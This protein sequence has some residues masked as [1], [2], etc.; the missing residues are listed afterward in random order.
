MSAMNFCQW[1]QVGVAA[2]SAVGGLIGL[3]MLGDTPP[4]QSCVWICAGVRRQRGRREADLD[5][6]AHARRH[7]RVVDLIEARPVVG[8][9]LGRQRRR[10]VRVDGDVAVQDAV[11]ARVAEAGLVVALLQRV[12]RVPPPRRRQDR[13]GVIGRDRALVE[14]APGRARRG[15]VDRQRDRRRSR[16]RPGR[17]RRVAAA[18]R[19]RRCPVPPAPPPPVPPVPLLPPPPHAPTSATVTTSDRRMNEAEDGE[20]GRNLDDCMRSLRNRLEYVPPTLRRSLAKSTVRS[21]RPC[22]LPLEGDHE[23]RQLVDLLG[24]QLAAELRHL[25]PVAEQQRV[26]GVGDDAPRPTSAFRGPSGWGRRSR[27]R[28]RSRGRCRSRWAT[29]GRA[30]G[31]PSTV[32][33]SGAPVS[34]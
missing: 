32:S 34:A 28:R 3:L 15:A 4:Y 16:R 6:R 33:T 18:G 13:V 22:H 2:A 31:P 14:A 23:R 17:R 20:K 9:R 24:G 30:R 10:G 1:S 27:P 26:A 12:L 19:R 21:R 8:G 5:D 11:E 7:D 25:V 29:A